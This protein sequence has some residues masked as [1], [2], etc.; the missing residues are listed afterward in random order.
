MA[1]C[2][3]GEVEVCL[4]GCSGTETRLERSAKSGRDLAA[5]HCRQDFGAMCCD[6]ICD[7]D[8]V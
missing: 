8:V 4:R 7:C 1:E 2:A 5:E 3:D 6:G